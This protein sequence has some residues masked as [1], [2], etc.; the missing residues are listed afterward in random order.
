MTPPELDPAIAEFYHRAPE[1]DRL[2]Q[3]AFALEGLRT[4]ELI[5]PCP[6]AARNGA[7][8]RRGCRCV[9]PLARGRRV[10]GPFGRPGAAAGRRSGAAERGPLPAA[11]L[12]PS[13]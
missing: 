8:C 4:R 12:V 2:E 11:R 5:A 6:A 10:Y 3:G 7:R 9:C 13:W 1:E